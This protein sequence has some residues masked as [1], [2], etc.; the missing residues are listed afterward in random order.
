MVNKHLDKEEPMQML[1]VDTNAVVMHLINQAK[2]VA[3][4]DLEY[5]RSK[6]HRSVSMRLNE[7]FSEHWTATISVDDESECKFPGGTVVLKKNGYPEIRGFFSYR[8][9]PLLFEYARDFCLSVG[10]GENI[11]ATQQLLKEALP[12]LKLS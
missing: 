4:Q 10:T 9:T 8:R 6:T 2:R 11:S 12:N 7:N 5:K 1:L 3:V